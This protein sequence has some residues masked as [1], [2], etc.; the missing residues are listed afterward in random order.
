ME[1]VFMTFLSGALVSF[2]TQIAKNHEVH[3][4]VVVAGM[5]IVFGV[6][7]WAFTQY[8]PEEL[9]T[10]IVGF[11]GGSM[12]TATLVYEWFIKRL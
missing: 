7:Y 9:Q 3:P 10:N 11:I 12:G 5:S 4:H 1:A 2:V 6:L 8:L